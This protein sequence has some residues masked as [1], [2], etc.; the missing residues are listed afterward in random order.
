MISPEPLLF[1][2]FLFIS[3]SLKAIYLRA[4]EGPS[5]LDAFED[6]QKDRGGGKGCWAKGTLLGLIYSFFKTSVLYRR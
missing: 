3:D 6:C 4:Y 5:F 2:F 1:D